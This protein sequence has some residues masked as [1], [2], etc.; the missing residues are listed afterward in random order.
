MDDRVLRELEEGINCNTHRLRVIADYF[1]EQGHGWL[2]RGVRLLV[3]MGKYPALGK[4][5]REEMWI[6]SLA[7][8]GQ[9][10]HQL[11]RVVGLRLN[12]F[13][14]RRR[15]FR[16]Y[17]TVW[18]AVADAALALNSLEDSGEGCKQFRFLLTDQNRVTVKEVEMVMPRVSALE[19]LNYCNWEVAEQEVYRVIVGPVSGWIVLF[20]GTEEI[21]RSLVAGLE[22]T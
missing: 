8:V 2:A 15:G 12:H 6:W 22:E 14:Y 20:D 17:K 7:N 9:L 10:G 11:D 3:E 5:E 21:G 1:E 13:E 19:Y 16:F 4:T 18:Q